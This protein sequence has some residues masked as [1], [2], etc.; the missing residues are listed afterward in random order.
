MQ[1]GAIKIGKRGTLVIPAQVRQY[2][3][4][5]DGSLVTIEERPEGLLLR[6]VG[7]EPL[8]AILDSLSKRNLCV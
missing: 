7:T 1:S 4:L 5:M 3:G 8:L 2:Y 6:P